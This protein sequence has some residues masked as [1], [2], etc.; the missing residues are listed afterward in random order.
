MYGP[1]QSEVETVRTVQQLDLS[2]QE[3]VEREAFALDFAL[4]R[5]QR[6]AYG[7][8]SLHLSDGATIEVPMAKLDGLVEEITKE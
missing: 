6:T 5:L 7:T 8:R 2:E 3:D 4:G 1:G